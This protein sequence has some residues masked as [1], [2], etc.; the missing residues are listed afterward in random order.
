MKTIAV[1]W[2]A[3]ALGV[4]AATL[5][6][7][8]ATTL[9]S[10]V[11]C[12]NRQMPQERSNGYRAPDVEARAQFRDVYRRMLGGECAFAL[13][14]ALDG[15][16]RL[17]RFTDTSNGRTY[18]VLMEIRDDDRDGHVDR[19]WGTFV[20]YDKATNETNHSA[21]H[22]IFDEGTER[23]AVAIFRDSDAR[24]FMMCG[25][26]RR[27]HGALGG[28]CEPK[29][30]VA[31]CAHQDDTFFQAAVVEMADYYGTKPWIHVQ[32]HGNTTCAPVSVYGSQGFARPQPDDSPLRTLRSRTAAHAPQVK[33][34]ELTGEG[35]TCIF[36]ATENV[37]GR[38]LNG[39]SDVCNKPGVAPSGRFAH[40]EQ[41]PA[42]R[43][44]A[45]WIDAVRETWGPRRRRRS[46]A[47]VHSR[48]A[49][50][51]SAGL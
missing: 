21:P 26:H 4:Q 44:P 27:A 20:T 11:A 14:P 30:G 37:A 6:C 22:P 39:S 28:A 49:S 42:Y 15:V 46:A 24:S 13:P 45:L 12:I 31:D 8:D 9:E 10:L 36:N 34:F 35:S 1:A 29:Y 2:A 43:D 25:A 40:I 3:C 18:C 5:D 41:L 51:S 50:S 7:P 32:W 47:T 19:G 38:F 48:G 33:P 16:M 17:R 23:Q